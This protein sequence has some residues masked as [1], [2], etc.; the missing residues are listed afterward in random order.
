M[1][2]AKQSLHRKLSPLRYV[3]TFII[4]SVSSHYDDQASAGFETRSLFDA[5]EPETTSQPAS[6]FDEWVT[7]PPMHCS[8][9]ITYW[10]AELNSPNPKYK[11]LARMALDYLSIPGTCFMT[12]HLVLDLH[13]CASFFCGRGACILCRGDIRQ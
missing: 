11:E 8:D 12:Y 6:Q 7:S 10:T 1:L 3:Q 13:V 5:F 9:P 4:T 2:R